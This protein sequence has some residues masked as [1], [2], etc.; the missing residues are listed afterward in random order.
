MSKILTLVK[1]TNRLPPP[2]YRRPSAAR[3]MSIFYDPST[4][5]V[6]SYPTTSHAP[7]HI[8]RLGTRQ[9]EGQDQD[10][11]AYIKIIMWSYSILECS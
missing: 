6:K 3:R 4:Y 1:P 5:L 9:P 11:H 10:T 7:L 8:H 2:V